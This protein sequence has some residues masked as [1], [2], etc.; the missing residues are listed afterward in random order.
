MAIGFKADSIAPLTESQS[1]S[2]LALSFTFSLWQARLLNSVKESVQIPNKS[3][4]DSGVK[5]TAIP[6]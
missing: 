6:V 3:D 1:R 4:H 2:G 5:P